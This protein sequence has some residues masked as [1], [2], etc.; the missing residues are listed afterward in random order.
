MRYRWKFDRKA[1][2]Q[3]EKLDKPVQRRL[4]NWLELNIS[5]TNNPRLFGKALEGEFKTLWRYRVGK[6]RIIADIVDDEFVVVVLK[7]DK[8]SDVYRNK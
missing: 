4:Y 6:Y 5:G 1:E 7:T 8:R 2:K 3:F